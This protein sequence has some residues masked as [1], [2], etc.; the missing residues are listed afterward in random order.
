ML[1]VPGNHD[2]PYAFPA[3]VTSP[4]REFERQWQTVEPIYASDARARRRAS[5]R[6]A[7]GTTSRAA[8]ATSNCGRAAAKLAQAAPG[9]LRVVALHHQLI[10]A[11]WRSH[12]KPVARRH[13]VLSELVAAGAELVVGGHIHQGAVAERREFEVLAGRRGRLRD[14]DRARASASRGRSGSARRAAASPT[15]PTSD[16]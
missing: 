4:W 3:R 10:N 5:T 7:R 2:I 11:P 6:S 1:A 9:A 15:A 16:H 8:S 13:H 12:K 14:L